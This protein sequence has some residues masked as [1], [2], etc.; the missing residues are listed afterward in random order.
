MKIHTPKSNFEFKDLPNA[1]VGIFGVRTER[2]I[3]SRSIKLDGQ[4]EL[5]VISAHRELHVA[6]P[7][8]HEKASEQSFHDLFAYIKG[9]NQNHEKFSMTAPVYE[10]HENELWHTSFYLEES[11]DQISSPTDP[12]LQ[13]IECD[14]II[15]AVVKFSGAAKAHDILAKR[16]ELRGWITRQGFEES[17]P[18]RLAQFD[19]PFAISFLRRNELQVA[20]NLGQRRSDDGSKTS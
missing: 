7:G 2:E 9:H 13:V 18:M 15:A 19:P 16:E 12:K 20:V 14:E 17:G 10:H 8:L 3:P 4:F 1:L 6:R 5:R 11:I